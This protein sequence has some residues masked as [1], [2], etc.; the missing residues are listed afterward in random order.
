M[1]DIVKPMTRQEQ[2]VLEF[3]AAGRRTQMPE[4][5]FRKSFLSFF[6]NEA[7][8]NLKNILL[9]EWIS[10]V[11]GPSYEA[12]LTD[13]AGR[14]TV[15]VPCIYNTTVSDK[16]DTNLST[17]YS[18]LIADYNRVKLSQPALADGYLKKALITKLDNESKPYVNVA[19][20]QKWAV[21]YNYFQRPDLANSVVSNIQPQS[22]LAA[23]SG[24]SNSGWDMEFD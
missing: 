10:I 21:F 4:H 6:C 9:N 15:I 16:T 24:P 1:N 22:P 13:Y 23:P 3:F 12:E 5:I 14:V 2:D 11:G 18:A 17:T 7:P 20:Q 19:N 8:D